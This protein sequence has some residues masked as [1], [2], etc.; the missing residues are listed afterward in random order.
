MPAFLYSLLVV[1]ILPLL[2]NFLLKLGASILKRQVNDFFLKEFFY[3][4]VVEYFLL[5]TL[6][7]ISG[8]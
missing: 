8:Y 4:S 1:I 6:R 7:P 2:P 5:L 3:F